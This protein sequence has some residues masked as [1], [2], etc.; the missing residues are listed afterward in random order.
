[1]PDKPPMTLMEAAKAIDAVPRRAIK[2]DQ[3]WENQL[4][5]TDLLDQLHTTLVADGDETRLRAENTFNADSCIANQKLVAALQEQLAAKERSFAE[6]SKI[7]DRVWKAL[8][9]SSYEQAKPYAIHEHVSHLKAKV[10]ELQATLDQERVRSIQLSFERAELQAENERLRQARESQRVVNGA[11]GTVLNANFQRIA[12][13]EKALRDAWTDATANESCL[14]C[15]HVLPEHS[16]DC[17]VPKAEALLK[18]AE[19]QKK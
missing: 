2:G 4:I 16:K 1:M 18:G 5:L 14:V 9:I 19:W 15:E 10:A 17:W 13:L 11:A 8:G 12:A 3:D 6:E 7:V